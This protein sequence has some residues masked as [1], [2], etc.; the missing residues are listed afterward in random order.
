MSMR[1]FTSG[2]SPIPSAGF[3]NTFAA[4]ARQFIEL[5]LNASRSSSDDE[6]WFSKS[7][8]VSADLNSSTCLLKNGTN[9]FFVELLD[10]F[11]DSSIDAN[12][13]STTASGTGSISES[14]SGLTG[15]LILSSGNNTGAATA[16][17]NQGN[18]IDYK[19]LGGNDVVILMDWDETSPAGTDVNI[20]LSDGTTHVNIPVDVNYDGGVTDRTR[21][22][23][24]IVID[25]SA[26]V[27]YWYEDA[28]S[29]GSV[30][31]SA[32]LS[33]L[34]NYYLRIDTS[35]SGSGSGSTVNVY[36]VG[37][38]DGDSGSSILQTGGSTITESD[39][40][41]NK[42][43]TSGDSTT[44]TSQVSADGGSS[45]GTFTNFNIVEVTGG[46]SLVYKITGSFLTS[47]DGTGDVQVP[48]MTQIAGFY[49]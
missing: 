24:K 10:R 46:T 41:A 33:S 32:D 8:F 44:I 14:G 21:I 35:R 38:L 49:E 27:A 3:N 39:S 4:F 9:A 23:S 15:K 5:S 30:P 29:T 45:F 34:S 22:V 40:F 36:E 42:V 48:R 19:D 11:N 16:I 31:S 28:T 7:S 20:Q 1:N 26:E 2:E 43:F 18:A 13:W 25:R 17:A 6:R 47:I 12:I 37:Y